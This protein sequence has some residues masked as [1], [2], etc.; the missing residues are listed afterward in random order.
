M[1]QL[2]ACL[3]LTLVTVGLHAQDHGLY[4][5]YKDYDGAISFTVPRWAI[6]AGSWFLDEK[7]DRKLLRKVHK[8]RVLVFEDQDAPVTKRDLQRFSQKAQRRR[9]EPLLTVR[10]GQT[11]IEIWG[12][13]RRNA[14][15]KVVVLLREPDTF[16]LV[17]LRGK[18]K[19]DEIAPLLEGLPNKFKGD[20]DNP[21]PLLPQNV[22]NVIR[23]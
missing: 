13:E 22:R 19:F 16:A 20:N 15:R 8:V 12:K 2:L 10:E 23:I 17:S 14:L 21:Q 3:A 9:L 18:I 11:R 1:K 4:W 6:H 5:K 7:Q